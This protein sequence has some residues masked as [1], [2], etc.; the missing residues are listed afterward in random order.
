MA[1]G[2]KEITFIVP[3]QARPAGAA[4]GAPATQGTVKASVRVGAQRG[5]GEPVRVVARAARTWWCS[6]SPTARRWCCTPKTRAT[7]CG[8]RPAMR[9]AARSRMPAAGEVRVSAAARLAGAAGRRRHAA[10]PAA[11]GQATLSAFEVITGLLQG[12]GRG[13]GDRGHHEQ[14]RRR[15]RRR[16]VR[17]LARSPLQPLKGSGTRRASVPAAA[18][19]GPLLV[20]VH[21]T[22]VD[23]ASTFGKLWTLH[24]RQVRE[25]FSHYGDRVYALDHPDARGKA[26]SPMR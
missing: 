7:C 26:R 10:R 12:P 6:A 23:T 3:G 19:G 9:R 8:R 14:A 22:F 15:G 4:R 25:L 17:A 13:P 21:G 2:A 16:R 18:D 5:S 1:T 11:V 24:P 20:L